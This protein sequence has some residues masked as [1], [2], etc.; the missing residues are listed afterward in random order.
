MVLSEKNS[1]NIK[2]GQRSR[3]PSPNGNVGP[4]PASPIDDEGAL[5][6]KNNCQAFT[7]ISAK[8]KFFIYIL[9]CCSFQ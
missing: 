4:S 3:G 2:N 6:T 8:G 1:A 5:N 9:V 7:N